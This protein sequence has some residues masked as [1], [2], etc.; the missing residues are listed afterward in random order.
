MKVFSR[1]I[2]I[3]G[4]PLLIGRQRRL[5]VYREKRLLANTAEMFYGRLE[6]IREQGGN[7]FYD[8]QLP[9]AIIKFKQGFGRLIHSKTD[10]GIVVV[11][12]SRILNKSYGERFLSAIPKCKIEIVTNRK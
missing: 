8:Y 6:Q 1:L 11:L 12:D 3:G 2:W 5:P 9:S 10:T 7:P 4:S